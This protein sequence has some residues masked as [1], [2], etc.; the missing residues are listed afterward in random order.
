MAGVKS[1]YGNRAWYNLYPENNIAGTAIQRLIDAG[2]QI[3]GLQKPS[4]FANGEKATA[5]WVD[6]H[7]PFNPRGDGYQDPSSSSSGA[8]AS[9]A[10]YEWLDLAVGSDT[11]GSIRNP[12]EVQGVFGNR[13][14]HGLVPLDNVMPLSEHLDTAGFLTRDPYLWDVAQSVLYGDNYTSFVDD[15]GEP[16]YPTTVYTVAFP[17]NGSGSDADAILVN[18]ASKVASFVGGNITALDLAEAWSDANVTGAQG[19]TLAEFLYETYATF[20][21]KEQIELV[22]DPFYADYAGK[23]TNSLGNSVHEYEAHG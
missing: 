22:R 16:V 4:Q 2:A 21:G 9:I 10:S 8:G 23:C 18:F 7:S 14:S 3:V 13:P 12:S 17:A 15:I 20:I 5:D 11:G 1:S 19:S 6:Y